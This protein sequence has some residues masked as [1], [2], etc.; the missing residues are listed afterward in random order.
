MSDHPMT[1]ELR[2]RLTTEY[3][4]QEIATLAEWIATAASYEGEAFV[5]PAGVWP[6]ECAVLGA[7][8]D[9]LLASFQPGDRGR[10]W[11]LAARHAGVVAPAGCTPIAASEA[12]VTAH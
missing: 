11:R 8:G 3:D 2:A 5:T 10:F 6:S 1:A 12:R 9:A 7:G 4:W